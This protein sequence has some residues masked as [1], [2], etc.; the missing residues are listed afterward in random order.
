MAGSLTSK[1][2]QVEGFAEAV[3]L[4]HGKGWSDGL[5]VVPPT[6]DR[7]LEFLE[8]AGL[9]PEQVVG[10]VP[11]RARTITAE[12]LAVN[13][14]MAGCLPEYMPVLV[15]AVE[16]ITDPQFKFN[17]LASLGSPWPLIIVN[18][19]IAREI[20]MNSGMYL[21]GPGSRPNATIARAVSLVLRNCAEAKVEGIQ[22]GQLGNPLRWCGCIAENEETAWTPLHV[23]RGVD[24]DSSAVT[25][26]SSYPGAP[27]HLTGL[28]NKPQ[29][30]LNVVCYSLPYCN[31]SVW[32]P[33][34]YTL[35][36]SPHHA[37][38]FIKEGWSKEDV[39]S[40]VMENTRS[41]IAELKRRGVWGTRFEEGFSEELLEIQPGDEE[42]QVYLFKE[43]GEYER[44]LILR[45][46][47]E[48]RAREVFVVVAGGNTGHRI[49]VVSPY[50]SSTNPVTKVIRRAGR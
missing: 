45:S 21:F 37:E 13:A 2:Y 4:Y 41:S 30:L 22:R 7:V 10:E 17:H 14:V 36:V 48:G 40:Y 3:E 50:A 5:P 35:I 47:K 34:S 27:H 29:R 6:E 44:Y 31:G 15:A 46:H 11:E 43:L 49:G 23:Q 19:P 24:R 12:K 33:G 16:A 38:L 8:Y 9:E 42:K 26:V 1:R 25:V 20:G 39:G 28:I 18:G 32:L